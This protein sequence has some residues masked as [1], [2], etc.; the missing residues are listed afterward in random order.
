[1]SLLS[2]GPIDNNMVAGV[3]P[4]TQITVRVDNRSDVM[5]ST[6]SVQGYADLDGFEFLFYNP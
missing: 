2:T 1:M 4:T 6:V 3:R 5:F